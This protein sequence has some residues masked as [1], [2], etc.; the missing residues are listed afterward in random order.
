MKEGEWECY[1][2]ADMNQWCEPLTRWGS[3]HGISKTVR[4]GRQPQ[5][6]PCRLRRREED[7]QADRR[8]R[9]QCCVQIDCLLTWSTCS[10]SAYHHSVS[11]VTVTVESEALSTSLRTYSVAAV[12]HIPGVAAIRAVPGR[13]TDIGVATFSTCCVGEG[14]EGEVFMWCGGEEGREGEVFTWCGRGE[15]GGE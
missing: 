9:C 11:T 15:G 8:G 1:S 5:C 6:H 13:S 7:T 14:R 12:Q 2:T 3:R 4:P 10:A